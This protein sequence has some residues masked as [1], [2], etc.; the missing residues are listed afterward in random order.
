MESDIFTPTNELRWHRHIVS[1]SWSSQWDE[2]YILTLQQ[3]WVGQTGKEEWRSLPEFVTKAEKM[4][5]YG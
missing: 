2:N 3:K 5:H 1:M 4:V